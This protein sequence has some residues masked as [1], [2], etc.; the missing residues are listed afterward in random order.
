[1]SKSLLPAKQ[2]GARERR[3]RRQRIVRRSVIPL[4]VVVGFLVWLLFFS[5]RPTVTLPP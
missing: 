5:S 1:M 3:Q 4:V 2:L